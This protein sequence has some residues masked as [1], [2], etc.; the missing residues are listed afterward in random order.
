MRMWLHLCTSLLLLGGAARAAES[1]SALAECYAESANRVEVG[2]CLNRR[3]AEAD[4]ELS[5]AVGVVRE[6]MARVDAVTGRQLGTRAFEHSQQTFIDFRAANCAWLA[7]Q[8][9]A[10]TGAGDVQRACE[11]RMTRARIEELRSQ[12][13]RPRGGATSEPPASEGRTASLTGSVWRLTRLLRD[14]QPIVIAPESTPSIEFDD[15]GRVREEQ[16]FLDA[17]H[18]DAPV[19]MAGDTLVLGNDDETIVLTFEH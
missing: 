7:A 4:A 14:G 17:L 15:A 1:S 13:D 10:G 19:R 11:I 9:G 6:Q 5:T 12:V 18:R 16:W 3:F 8:M 2:E